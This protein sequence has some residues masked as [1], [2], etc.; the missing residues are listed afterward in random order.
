MKQRLV[1][2]LAAAVLAVGCTTITAGAFTDTDR[3]LGGERHQ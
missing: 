2:W 1:K 3:P